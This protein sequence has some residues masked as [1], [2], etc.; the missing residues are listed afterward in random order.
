MV[1]AVQA[2]VGVRVACRST[3]PGPTPLAEV[4]PAVDGPVALQAGGMAQGQ[5]EVMQQGVV[6]MHQAGPAAELPALD[7]L[8]HQNGCVGPG[9]LGSFEWIPVQHG[10]SQLKQET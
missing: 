2:A 10:V 3:W 4:Q 9:L 7:L 5:A 8:Q 6:Q 1:A